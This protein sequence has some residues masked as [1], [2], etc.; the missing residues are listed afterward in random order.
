VE[1]AQRGWVALQ[2]VQPY[3]GC[4]LCAQLDRQIDQHWTA[5]GQHR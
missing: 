2:L 4:H 3:A 1:A 5:T